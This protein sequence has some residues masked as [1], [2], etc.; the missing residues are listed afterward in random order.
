MTVRVVTVKGCE[1]CGPLAIAANSVVITGT[2]G[3]RQIHYWCP[4][5]RALT[6]TASDPDLI[7]E[8]VAAGAV[9]SIGPWMPLRWLCPG[10]GTSRRTDATDLVVKAPDG[11][12]P[13]YQTGAVCDNEACL[14]VVYRTAS[15]ST[16]MTLIAHGAHVIVP[17]SEDVTAKTS[18][19]LPIWLTDTEIG[20][21]TDLT[22]DELGALVDGLRADRPE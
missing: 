21:L 20:A 15:E 5:D 7:D 11:Y 2:P 14:A 4:C 19:H 13:T 10:C 22:E 6:F 9:V 3:A 1:R 12:C 16:A 18:D 8:L 17:P